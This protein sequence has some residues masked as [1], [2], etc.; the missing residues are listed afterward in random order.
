[1]GTLCI[2]TEVFFSGFF[3]FSL[4]IGGTSHFSH[5]VFLHFIVETIYIPL[6]TDDYSYTDCPYIM[7]FCEMSI[8]KAST[9]TDQERKCFVF[10]LLNFKN[11]LKFRIK[12]LWYRFHVKVF[13]KVKI[14]IELKRQ[15]IDSTLNNNRGRKE[16]M[17][18]QT[19]GRKIEKTE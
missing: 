6:I 14:N 17:K 15:E 18:Y 16:A 12:V 11:T 5:F 7:F 8:F 19:R 1:M 2:P 13:Q 3:T 4:T 9:H 10:L